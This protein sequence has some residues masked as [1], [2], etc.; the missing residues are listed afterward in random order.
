MNKT[1][2]V[3]VLATTASII[4]LNIYRHKDTNIHPGGDVDPIAYLQKKTT[5]TGGYNYL[6][7]KST[8]RTYLISN[9]SFTQHPFSEHELLQHIPSIA[10]VKDYP[11]NSSFY[12]GMRS[13]SPQA[14]MTLSNAVVHIP[15]NENRL[16]AFF[17]DHPSDYQVVEALAAEYL[18]H[19]AD[20]IFK[21]M[22]EYP[23]DTG[24]FGFDVKEEHYKLGDLEEKYGIHIVTL[25]GQTAHLWFT[26]TYSSP[27][28]P[29][30]PLFRQD[31][32]AKILQSA[33]VKID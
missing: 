19:L 1:K 28:N 7:N 25:P 8:Y 30:A 17:E 6:V 9:A 22:K 31:E 32:V 14:N 33:D 11:V 29:D 10:T 12:F 21:R 18:R 24:S 26:I 3:V 5:F 2:L 16:R 27:P 4:A 20:P 13:P 23:P 15:Y